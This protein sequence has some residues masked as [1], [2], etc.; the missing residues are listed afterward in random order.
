M[1]KSAL[2]LLGALLAASS[3]ASQE[4]NNLIVP[5]AAAPRILILAA[6]DTAAANGTHFRS[7]ITVINLRNATQ[8]MQLYWLPQGTS[9]TDIAP[10]Y[11]EV[12]PFEEFSSENFVSDVMHQTGL[13]GIE[14]VGVDEELRFDPNALLHVTS[15]IWTPRPDGGDGTMS[16]TFP[17]IV[18]TGSSSKVKTI[19]GMRRSAHYRLNAGISNPTPE[20]RRYRVSA[21]VAL[22]AG[23]TEITQS[24]VE[25]PPRSIRQDLVGGSGAGIAQIV[26]EDISTANPPAGEWHA[27]ASSIDN[28]SG[29]A[30]SQ[31][32]VPGS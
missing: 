32:A 27:W 19:Y 6:G 28:D 31:V 20:Y 17:A 14:I 22:S 12:G 9:G 4:T 21:F 7:D 24:T 16:Q 25:V 10:V 2:L 1:Q 5:Q 18:V 23:G 11:M 13:G 15:R 26:I 30:W 8:R 29:D 3:A